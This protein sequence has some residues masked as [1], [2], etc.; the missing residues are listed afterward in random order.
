[1]GKVADGLQK[2]LK[3]S[4][5]LNKLRQNEELQ[6]A[7]REILGDETIESAQQEIAGTLKSIKSIKKQVTAKKNELERDGVFEKISKTSNW[8]TE[9][10]FEKISNMKSSSQQ[11]DGFEKMTSPTTSI[12]GYI[13]RKV[14]DTGFEKFSAS[15]PVTKLRER[16]T[17]FSA[18]VKE[19]ANTSSLQSI[20]E[21]VR[22]QGSNLNIQAIKNHGAILTEKLMEQG[23]PALSSKGNAFAEKMRV[24]GSNLSIEAIKTHGTSLAEKLGSPGSPV[25]VESL[26]NQG[27]VMTSRFTGQ[28][29]TQLYERGVTFA[30]KVSPSSIE[31]LKNHGTAMAEKFREPSQY[32]EKSASFVH[33][34][35]QG[36]EILRDQNTAQLIE[37]GVSLSASAS[38]F[39]DTNHLFETGASL[40]IRTMR[41]RS[42]SQ[43][44][45]SLVADPTS[46]A[47][48]IGKTALTGKLNQI[49]V[50]G[51]VSE[52]ATFTS[53]IPGLNLAVLP[54]ADSPT[55]TDIDNLKKHSLSPR[56]MSDPVRKKGAALVEKIKQTGARPENE[57]LTNSSRNTIPNTNETESKS[58]VDKIK[59]S[60]TKL[61]ADSIKN[62]VISRFSSGSGGEGHNESNGTSLVNKI[63]ENTNKLNTEAIKSQVTNSLKLSTNGEGES[64][65]LIDT[66]KEKDLINKF[67]EGTSNLNT[68]VIKS[69]VSSSLGLANDGE[70]ESKSL[71]DNIKERDIVNKFKEGIN[72]E[73]IKTQVSTTFGL[74]NNEL[75]NRN[76]S[77]SLVDK[78]KGGAAKLDA[79][80]NDNS[81]VNKIKQN[82]NKLNTGAIKEQVSASLKLST[83]GEGESK[84][85]IDTIKE[86]DLINKFKEGTSNLNTEVIKSQ[87]S[88]SLGLA[89]DG[90]GE[91]KS[92]VDKIKENGTKLKTNTIKEKLVKSL[93]MRN[94]EDI[95]QVEDGSQIIITTEL[96]SDPNT[97]PQSATKQDGGLLIDD[98]IT[99]EKRPSFLQQRR[100]SQIDT[101]NLDQTLSSYQSESPLLSPDLQ[102]CSA[103]V[104]TERKSSK[105]DDDLLKPV[106]GVGVGDTDEGS[107]VVSHDSS[108]AEDKFSLSPHAVSS[109]ITPSQSDFSP[110]LDAARSL[111]VESAASSGDN[112]RELFQGDAQLGDTV[113]SL[114]APGGEPSDVTKQLLK[115][116]DKVK[117]ISERQ[118]SDDAFLSSPLTRYGSVDSPAAPRRSPSPSFVGKN[119]NL[120]TAEVENSDVVIKEDCDTFEKVGSTL[121]Q[122]DVTRVDSHSSDSDSGKIKSEL[123][124]G[125]L[126]PKTA[127]RKRCESESSHKSDEHDLWSGKLSSMSSCSPLHGAS[128]SDN[129][130]S[131]SASDLN[132]QLSTGV[133]AD[134]VLYFT[135]KEGTE[136]FP[137]AVSLELDTAQVTSPR[138]EFCFLDLDPNTPF[139]PAPFSD[140][141]SLHNSTKRSLFIEEDVKKTIDS[142]NDNQLRELARLTRDVRSMRDK[143][144]KRN[145]SLFSLLKK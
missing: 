28:S 53:T 122:L 101:N 117:D 17:A 39:K 38:K 77:Q 51:V 84:S 83:K 102:Y 92:L 123:S 79:V 119:K 57:K 116:K 70:G 137:T 18:T 114:P 12:Q 67:K 24:Q 10:G 134:T 104:P 81:L 62:Q 109:N 106:S 129:F 35:S 97:T 2:V 63:K 80:A 87:V 26:K 130:D 15:T 41:D 14:D 90:D 45:A 30:E 124:P 120:P 94:G 131:P 20:T 8:V 52:V 58:L 11:N 1:M 9:R 50:L 121:V 141:E 82:T 64:K 143:M 139:V 54:K 40:A 93:G 34:I 91:S 115:V 5:D 136:E 95:Q 78:I 133:L 46:I 99:A 66:I 125:L 111:L 108:S 112:L 140:D 22:A 37:K 144:R 16:G 61:H 142:W 31:S 55:T 23:S 138:S 43:T 6:A 27:T 96:S 44:A 3:I 110:L 127:R 19:K 47:H 74:S 71:M 60:G 107:H 98:L 89:N 135:E 118:G 49:P 68:E 132:Q 25:T 75:E 86:K 72:A 128:H 65:S 56:L 42:P 48:K 105:P 7:A 126:S 29:P 88:S 21:Q 113:K 76:R 32:R 103:P 13:K 59:E 85:L 4:E 145:E 73:S 33:K 69:Q 100:P 36:A